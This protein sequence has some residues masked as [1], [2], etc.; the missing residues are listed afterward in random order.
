MPSGLRSPKDLVNSKYIVMPAE[1]PPDLKS[2]FPGVIPAKGQ[3][4]PTR[5]YPYRRQSSLSE[6][7]AEVPQ[8]FQP[9]QGGVYQFLLGRDK[10]PVALSKAEILAELK[11]LK[12]P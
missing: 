8:D 6:P 12:Q 7:T 9:Q 5:Q 3:K 11:T 2:P 1:T 4:F 10:F